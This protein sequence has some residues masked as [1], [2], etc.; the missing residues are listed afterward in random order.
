MRLVSKRLSKTTSLYSG[1]SH[2]NTRWRMKVLWSEIQWGTAPAQSGT[3]SRLCW[4]CCVECIPALVRVSRAECFSDPM[5]ASIVLSHGRM[6]E[7]VDNKLKN[8]MGWIRFLF[9]PLENRVMACCNLPQRVK[10]R[11]LFQIHFSHLLLLG[12]FTRMW[13]RWR[14]GRG[15]CEPNAS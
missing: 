3:C 6:K 9:E 2:F 13:G 4:L 10:S 15:S 7:N 12:A 8:L 14:N 1:A 11:I 5:L